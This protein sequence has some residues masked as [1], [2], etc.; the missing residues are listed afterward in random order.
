MHEIVRQTNAKKKSDRQYRDKQDPTFQV[1]DIVILA[2][3]P[4]SFNTEHFS[5]VDRDK[6]TIKCT[7]F[8]IVTK[9]RQ[10]LTLHTVPCT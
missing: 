3:L 8:N 4:N 1:V 5:A 7:Y 9:E 10:S 2:S 6:Y